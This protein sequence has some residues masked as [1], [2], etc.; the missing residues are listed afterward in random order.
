MAGDLIFAPDGGDDAVVAAVAQAL[1]RS[2]ARRVAIAGGATPAAILPKLC[3]ANIAWHGVSICPT[4]D[5]IAPEASAASNIGALRRAFAGT[6][7]RVEALQIGRSPG[8]FDLVWLG[9]GADGHIASLFP[10]PAVDVAAPPAI[11][12]LTP[13]PLPVEAPFARL[14][15]N[16]AAIADAEKIILVAR[17]AG[18]RAVLDGPRRDLPIWRLLKVL[19]APITVFWTA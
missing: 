6:T 11:I 17:G 7:A 16:Y 1:E 14:T 15:L 8:R 13:Q 4:D 12:A 9:L 2:G 10:A 19:S 5:R 18:K 3:A